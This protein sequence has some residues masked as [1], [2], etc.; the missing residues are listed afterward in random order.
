MLRMAPLLRGGEFKNMRHF[1]VDMILGESLI[2]RLNVIA[3]NFNK[4]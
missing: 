4:I 1:I 2:Y 3:K